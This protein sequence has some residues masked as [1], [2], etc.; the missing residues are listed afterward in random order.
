V[1]AKAY[2]DDFLFSFACKLFLKDL[3]TTLPGTREDRVDPDS[4]PHLF[5]VLSYLAGGSGSF[6]PLFWG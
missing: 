3:D 4:K 2:P 6:G 1:N 5:Y